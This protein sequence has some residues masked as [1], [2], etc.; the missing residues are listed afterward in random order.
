MALKTI[1]RHLRF[2]ANE[3]G[4]IPAGS[5]IKDSPQSCGQTLKS[6]RFLHHRPWKLQKST[7]NRPLI[8]HL[9]WIFAHSFATPSIWKFRALISCGRR[10]NWR[11]RRR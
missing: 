4:V 7:T 10:A 3:T 11:L 8:S 5:L 6:N 1:L 9:W 2:V